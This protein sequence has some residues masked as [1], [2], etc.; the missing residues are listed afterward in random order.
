MAQVIKGSFNTTSAEGRYLTF[1]WAVNSTSIIENYKEIY[2]SV[3]G[4]GVGGYV[5]GGN[6]KVV[7]DGETV[8][9][10]STR[11]EIWVDT[12]IA[13]GYKKIYHTENGTRS[14]SASVEAGIF[15]VAVNCRGSGSWELPT[16]P[17]NLSITSCYV[18][19]ITET[20]AV[21]NWSV[22]DPRDSTYYSFDN[23]ATW[24][25]SATDGESLASDLKSGSFTILNLTANKTYNIKVKIKRT[26]S[27]LWT[28]SGTVT[29]TTL[30]YPHCT[31]SPDFVIGDPLKLD[32]YNPLGR[33]ITVRGYAKSN[34][35]QIFAG[36]TTSTSLSGFNVDDENGGATVQYNSIPNAQSG[37]YRVVVSW[38]GASMERDAGTYR[39]RGNEI[40]TINGFDY[41][42]G[43]DAVVAIT[44]D[45]TQIVQNKSMLKARFHAATGNYGAS[46]SS[47]ILECNGINKGG[48]DAGSYDIGTIDSSRDVELKLTAYDSRGLSASKS[49]T[50]KMVAYEAPKATVDLRRLNNYEDETYLTVDG[51]VSSVLGKNTMT[52]QYRY[53]PSGGSFG[54]FA[55]IADKAM[56]TLSL[57]KN[58]IYIFNV[59]VTDI[60]GSKFDAEYELYKGVFPLFIDTVKNSVGI[61]C[62]PKHKNSLE[63]NGLIPPVATSIDSISSLD[64][65]T[66]ELKRS[67]I[68]TVGQGD[69]WYNLINIRHRNGEEDGQYYGFQIIAPMLTKHGKMQ[70]R[71][72]DST[73]WGEWRYLQEEGNILFE[74]DSSTNVNLGD[75]VAHYNFLEI[76]YSLKTSGEDYFQSVKVHNP[77]G[78]KCSLIATNASSGYVIFGIGAVL[79]DGYAITFLANNTFIGSD[80]NNAVT[81]DEIHIYKVVGYR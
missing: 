3:V 41:I 15:E 64:D 29:F 69:S 12:V 9:N 25:G 13:S 32:F 63:V 55:T 54:S 62:F 76:Y 77:Q 11:R 61:N 33:E 45:N 74:G 40:P 34:G 58:N 20:S 59:V 60:F 17:R 65:V 52:I 5:I 38:N 73:G 72:H 1:N 42:D 43:N 6:F 81:T 7:I 37:G 49:I 46:I 22:S 53:R 70:V 44:G 47:Y 28:E 31:G 10:N 14:F 50:V 68:Y 75:S 66:G 24:I 21:I 30:N 4:A 8:Y 26:D 16:I 80:M 35:A 79:L 71:N 36:K 18:S 48:Y 56:Q 23:G 67:G 27:Q 78:K 39:I 57:D 2:W 19:N 51:S